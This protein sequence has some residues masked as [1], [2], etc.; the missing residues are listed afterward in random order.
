[1]EPS[2][3]AEQIADHLRRSILLGEIGPGES[4]KERDNAA[5]LGVSRTPMREA[6]RILAN[7]GLVMLRPSRSPIAANP[8]YKEV[9]DDLT[10][11][12]TLE[13]LS[14]KLAC[15]NALAPELCKIR[16]LHEKMVEVSDTADPVVFFETDMAFHRSIAQASHN[17]SLIDTYGNYL[18][19][20][21]RVRFLAARK[22]PDR[23]RV[24]EQ[25]GQMATG[26]EARDA[27]LVTQVLANHIGHIEASVRGYFRDE[28]NGG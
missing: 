23:A 10:V 26:L 6:I 17:E 19:R 3:L 2:T 27:D 14:G 22:G 25:H 28:K 4:I 11:M 18:A 12:Q 21:W 9:Q 24:L 13:M 16:K 20:L 8:S 7:E 1:M 5:E 15:K